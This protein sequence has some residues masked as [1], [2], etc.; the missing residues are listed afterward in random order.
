MDVAHGVAEMS[1]M[2]ILVFCSHSKI[3][4]LFSRIRK[5]RLETQAKSIGVYQIVRLVEHNREGTFWSVDI[6]HPSKSSP[7]DQ[8]RAETS[9]MV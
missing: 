1:F 3:N 7:N 4:K 2:M 9:E 6:M 8:F 5:N